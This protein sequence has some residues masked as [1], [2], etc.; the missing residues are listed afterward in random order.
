[1]RANLIP[2]IEDDSHSPGTSCLQ[3][4]LKVEINTPAA[5]CTGPE[6]RASV[7]EASTSIISGSQE[8]C[9]S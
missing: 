3:T 9:A 5:W 6:L 1:M 7:P 4:E 2:S 8:D